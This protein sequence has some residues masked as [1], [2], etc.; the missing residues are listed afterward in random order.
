MTDYAAPASQA[1]PLAIT[2]KKVAHHLRNL[3]LIMVSYAVDTAVLLLFR[4]VGTI[5]WAPVLAYLAAGLIITGTTYVLIASGW[6][7][8]LRDPS[9]I[10]PHTLAAQ[11]LMLGGMVLVPELGF[12]FALLLFIVYSSLTLS[13]DVKRSILAW[14]LAS[15]GM[16][17]ALTLSPRPLHIPD[18]TLAEQ[19]ISFGFFVIT[20]WRCMWIGAFNSQMTGLLKKRG[21]ELAALTAQ[22]DQLAHHDELTGLLNRRSLLA[23]LH[24]E[25]QRARRS[26]LPLSVAMM[27]IDRFKSINDN[28]GHL[29][30]DR[31]LRLFA[32]T[33]SALA[34][35]SDRFGRYGGEEFMLLMTGTDSTGAQVPVL[36]MHEALAQADW[37]HAVAP[38]LRATF[39]CGIA[40]LQP[41]DTAESLI[42][43]ADDALYRA[44]A[45][46]RN[47]T[48]L[49]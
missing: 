49:G 47:C 48:R 31:T 19:L 3:R 16:A 25:M 14:G 8:R 9:L 38:G 18:S 37:D 21:L 6:S 11:G 34:R 12:M 24:E 29:A 23:D 43:R 41:A 30:G 10:I 1:V 35:K 4:L 13:L 42:K 27:D 40:T 45:D 22:V 26:R 5:G 39:S 20:L 36:R 32:T 44:K 2:D 17:V 46:G 15:A 7:Q 28:L 33:L